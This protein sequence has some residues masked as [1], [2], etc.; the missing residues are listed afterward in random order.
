MAMVFGSRLHSSAAWFP[1]TAALLR[2]CFNS[3]IGE[4]FLG[5]QGDASETAAPSQPEEDAGCAC[6]GAT[7]EDKA[8]GQQEPGPVEGVS[9][10]DG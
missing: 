8:R 4:P 3:I 10:S 2:R 5:R 7:D 9:A 1:W 6:P